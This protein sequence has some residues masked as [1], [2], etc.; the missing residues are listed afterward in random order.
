MSDV[1]AWA[2]DIVASMSDQEVLRV[3][4]EG[5]EGFRDALSRRSMQS[6]AAD[7][8]QALTDDVERLCRERA[9]GGLSGDLLSEE[10]EGN[11]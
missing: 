3:V 9:V 10:S 11:R 7:D 1:R 5:A 8:L 6:F 4:S 2:A